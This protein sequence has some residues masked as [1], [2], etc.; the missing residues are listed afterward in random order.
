MSDPVTLDL[1][2]L[3]E[4]YEDDREGMLEILQLAVENAYSHLKLV[5][6]AVEAHDAAELRGAAHAIRGACLNVGA[7]ESGQR[8]TELE[9][10]AVAQQ[11]EAIPAGIAALREAIGRL[12]VRVAGFPSEG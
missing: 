1:E 7:L 3:T 5:D 4:I 11:W 10:A 12:E 6:A 2:R 8:A 9:A